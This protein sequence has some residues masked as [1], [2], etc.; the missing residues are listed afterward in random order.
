MEW[1][2]K[3]TPELDALILAALFAVHVFARLTGG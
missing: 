2:Q 1:R 3:L